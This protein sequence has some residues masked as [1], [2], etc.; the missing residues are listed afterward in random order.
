MKY[1]VNEFFIS[2]YVRRS[3]DFLDD[4]FIGSW[5]IIELK[6][7]MES[8][9]MF[10]TVALHVNELDDGSFDSDSFKLT[11]TK[12]IF[13]DAHVFIDDVLTVTLYSETFK[14][15]A[16][17][18]DTAII[19]VYRNVF[20]DLE[21]ISHMDNVVYDDINCRELTFDKSYSIKDYRDEMYDIFDGYFDDYFL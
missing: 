3:L 20:I 13:D 10:V 1:L 17:F 18:A 2:L 6:D 16:T 21:G 7:Y 15:V 19:K 9:F 4:N 12:D 8:S 5:S 11:N 14:M